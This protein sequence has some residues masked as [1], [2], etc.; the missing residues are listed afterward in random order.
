MNLLN[1]QTLEEFKKSHS[2]WIEEPSLKVKRELNSYKA[3]N[4]RKVYHK[5]NIVLSGLKVLGG[6]MAR[7]ERK[8]RGHTW[9]K[10]NNNKNWKNWSPLLRD[11][12][13]AKIINI[14][15]L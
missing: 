2:G 9:S 11:M 13:K 10:I 6:G 3:I 12:V 1:I 4:N 14:D 8:E 5:S 15:D 7:L